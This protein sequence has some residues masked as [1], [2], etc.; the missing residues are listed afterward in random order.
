MEE[1]AILAGEK[2]SF[3]MNVFL[4]N[5]ERLLKFKLAFTRGT[6]MRFV[7]VHFLFNRVFRPLPVLEG[8]VSQQTSLQTVDVVTEITLKLCLSLFQFIP[9]SEVSLQ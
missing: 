2:I 4:M 9:S 5:E 3:S 7:L 6:I 8:F 1:S